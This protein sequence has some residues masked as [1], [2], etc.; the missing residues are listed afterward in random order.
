M[1]PA[2]GLGVGSGSVRSKFIT[3]ENFENITDKHNNPFRFPQQTER[4][5][6]MGERDRELRK[7]DNDKYKVTQLHASNTNYIDTLAQ[8]QI[9]D[10]LPREGLLTTVKQIGGE[11]PRKI[12]SLKPHIAFS[13]ASGVSSSILAIQTTQDGSMPYL[14]TEQGEEERGSFATQRHSIVTSGRNLRKSPMRTMQQESGSRFL[15]PKRSASVTSNPLRYLTN[16]KQEKESP[17]L[18]ISSSR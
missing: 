9:R 1:L 16:D 14:K 11:I 5:M 8:R 4:L 17:R 12:V 18:F 13:K 10:K 15:T 7:L 6:I 3:S 2:I